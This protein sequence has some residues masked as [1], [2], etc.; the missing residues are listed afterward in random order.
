M[1][2]SPRLCRLALTV[3]LAG[4]VVAGCGL[5]DPA[6]SI[7]LIDRLNPFSW[8]RTARTHF[9]KTDDGWTLALERYGPPKNRPGAPPVV[10]AHGFG[11]NGSF[12]SLA[13]GGDLPSRLAAEGFDVWVLNWRGAGDSTKWAFKLPELYQEFDGWKPR[14]AEG[15]AGKLER[16]SDAHLAN[17]TTDPKFFSWTLDDY[18]QHD[19]PAVLDYVTKVT[20]HQ[21][22]LWVGHSM[23]GNVALAYLATHP[24]EAGRFAGLATV[25]SQVTMPSNRLLAEYLKELAITRAEAFKGVKGFSSAL[26]AAGEPARELFFRTSNVSRRVLA[27]LERVATDSPGLGVIDQYLDLTGSGTLK[28]ADKGLDYSRLVGQVDVPILITAGAA[29]VVAPPVVQRQLYRAV[30]SKDKKLVLFGREEG[31]STD[32]G[33]GDPIVGQSAPR[34]IYPVLIQWLMRHS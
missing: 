24:E 13:P 8:Q 7:R 25:G 10:L 30:S 5:F 32:Y 2:R 14:G 3:T 20:G 22:V 27:V 11:Y 18:V 26:Q 1:E 21:R 4:L 28:S 19:V 31:F 6:H 16:L 34:E 9:I 29:D 33:H 15:V 23:G 17:V 12:W